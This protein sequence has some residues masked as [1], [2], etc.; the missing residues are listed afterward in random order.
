MNIDERCRRFCRVMTV[1]L[2]G[3][4]I[5][6]PDCCKQVSITQVESDV[7]RHY[8]LIPLVLPMSNTKLK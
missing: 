7:A 3:K 2:G 4:Y 6:Q 8:D 1:S 5:R